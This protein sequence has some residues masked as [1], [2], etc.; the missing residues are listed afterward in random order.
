MTAHTTTQS[1]QTA[2][3]VPANV[4]QVALAYLRGMGTEG[5]I[6]NRAPHDR[7]FPPPTS[8]RP[9]N[10]L[11]ASAAYTVSLL[12]TIPFSIYLRGELTIA[13]FL[14]ASSQAILGYFIGIYSVHFFATGPR[15]PCP[16]WPPFV[17]RYFRSE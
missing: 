10:L 17:R 6:P 7:I 3:N 5:V 11:I 12:F 1:S 14:F 16:A 9:E 8:T 15:P 4:A 2:K 13:P